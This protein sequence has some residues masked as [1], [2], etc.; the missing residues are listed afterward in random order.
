[1]RENRKEKMVHYYLSQENG[2]EGGL[3]SSFGAINENVIFDKLL[4]VVKISLHAYT[5]T[6]IY[7]Y[8]YF[9]FYFLFVAIITAN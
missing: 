6:N 4:L 1:M 2:G 8:L 9:L 5:Y 3:F 7:I